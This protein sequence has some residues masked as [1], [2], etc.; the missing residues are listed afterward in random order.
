MKNYRTCVKEKWPTTQRTADTKKAVKGY[1]NVK[2]K[3]GKF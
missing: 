1:R 2:G 3:T